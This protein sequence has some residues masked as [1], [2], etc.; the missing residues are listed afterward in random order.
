M[1]AAHDRGALRSRGVAAARPPVYEPALFFYVFVHKHLPGFAAQDPRLAVLEQVDR[2][3]ETYGLKPAGKTWPHERPTDIDLLGLHRSSSTF[4][5]L[6]NLRR[7]ETH[8]DGTPH[9]L[10]QCLLYA[11][12]DTLVVQILVGKL[13]GWE[14]S[15]GDGWRELTGSLRAGFAGS[16][17]ERAGARTFGASLVYWAIA[18]DGVGPLEYGADVDALMKGRAHGYT[19]TDIGPLWW[20]SLPVFP[21]SAGISQDRWVLVTPRTPDAEREANRRYNQVRVDGPPAFVSLAVARHKFTFEWQGYLQEHDQL[22]RVRQSLDRRARWIVE[23]QRYHGEQLSELGTRQSVEFQQ[24]LTRA[25]NNLAD[26]RQTVSLVKELRRTLHISRRNFLTHCPAL[27]SAEG[28]RRVAFAEDQA[29]AASAFLATWQEQRAE[30]IFRHELGRMQ[31]LCDQLDADIEYADLLV[32]R[33]G[34]ALRSGA[35]QMRLASERAL[36]AIS[37][38]GD[39]DTA[40]VVASL[41]VLLALELLRLGGTLE[42]RPAL[43][44]NLMM[45]SAAGSFALVLMITGRGRAKTRLQ[46]GSFAVAVGFLAGCLAAGVWGGVSPVPA[47]FAWTNAAAVAVGALAGGLAHWTIELRSLRRRRRRQS[48]RAQAAATLDRLVYAA[49]ELPD[50]LE[51]LPPPTAYHLALESALP[52]RVARRNAAEAARRGISTEELTELGLQYSATDVGEV[53]G[54]RY[55]APP[56]RMAEVVERIRAVTHP[57]AIEYRNATTVLG[58]RTVGRGEQ[59]VRENDPAYRGKY[60]GFHLNDKAIHID[61][62]LWGVG[63]RK[64]LSLMA[65]IQIR[66]PL[67]CLVADWFHA[68][69]T[70]EP[71]SAGGA[72]IQTRSVPWL[73]GFFDRSCP[74]LNRLLARAVTL[75]SDVELLV[76]RDLMDWEERRGAR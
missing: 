8:D 67:Q 72:E 58:K 62:D 24:K 71:G 46:R 50:L 40:F 53:I 54:I 75:L 49:E 76:F 34:A 17:L 51:D 31:G 22:E 2:F 59:D 36:G 11:H 18:A 47:W 66:T 37:R 45:L 52:E 6:T 27:I 30:E 13:E 65:E 12:H 39:I 70:G 35:E 7:E 73:V 38:S 25:T 69:M 41:S 43:S 48:R 29:Q 19:E 21:E 55:V 74:W 26:Y 10:W 57:V 15:L 5:R 33:H 68:I 32:E 28:A 63:A 56:R 14:G 9:T 23:T 16:A 42:Q 1:H 44:A 60:R 4:R 20:G 3:A 64:D 61:V